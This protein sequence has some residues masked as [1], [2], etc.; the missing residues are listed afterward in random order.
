M[1]EQLSDMRD[2]APLDRAVG[3]DSYVV[4]GEKMSVDRAA[5]IVAWE[6]SFEGSYSVI[7]GSLNTSQESSIPSNFVTVSDNATIQR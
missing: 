1:V 5:R 3:Q 6:D 2:G 7:I 4:V